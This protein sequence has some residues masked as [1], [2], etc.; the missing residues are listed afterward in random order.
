MRG[1]PDAA[2]R[3]PMKA[4]FYE[5]ELWKRELEGIL[6]PML[7]EYVVVLV[8]TPRVRFSGQNNWGAKMTR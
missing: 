4:E 8:E 7:D 1:F 5:G 3:E 6:M 2:S